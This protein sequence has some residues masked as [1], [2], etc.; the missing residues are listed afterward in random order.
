[1]T[2]DALLFKRL[3]LTYLPAMMEIERAAFRSPWSA[4]MMRDSLQAAHIEAWGLVNANDELLAF[5]ITSIVADECEIL[6]MSVAPQYH[7]Q[8]YGD[9]LMAFL[10]G[11]AK[12]QK[13]AKIYLDVN[14]NNDPAIQY[15]KKHGFEQTGVRKQY[16]EIPGAQERDDALLMAREL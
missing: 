15:Y 3:D 9:K 10:L 12:Q 7:R 11:H 6:S 8:G 1:M 13:A 4:G 16:Y 5:S 2:S 14:V